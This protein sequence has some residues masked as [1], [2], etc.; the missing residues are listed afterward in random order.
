MPFGL[1]L[2]N[3]YIEFVQVCDHT[4]MSQFDACF[5]VIFGN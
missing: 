3:Y 4:I 1:I 5:E 2:G